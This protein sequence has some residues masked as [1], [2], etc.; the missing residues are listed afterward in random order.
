MSKLSKTILNTIHKQKI[1][2]RSRW[3]FIALH[4]V[5]WVCFG[6]TLIIGIV[7]VS[8]LFLEMNMPER[9]YMDWVPLPGPLQIL[10]YLPF[11]WWFGSLLCVS[12]AYFVFH[13]TDRWYRIGTTWIVSILIL[14]SLL[15]WYILH[16][17][18]VNEM[19]ERNMQHLIPP[20]ER[21]RNDFRRWMP[22]PKSG[23]L[24]GKIQAVDDTLYTV[25]CPDKTLWKVTL[26]C[27]TEG[28]KTRQKDIKLNQPIMF[29]GSIQ[30]DET[31]KTFE[32]TDIQIPP[33]N[34]KGKIRNLLLPPPPPQTS[35]KN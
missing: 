34:R 7:A 12:I 3:Y 4:G 23:I 18:K 32:A 35:E 33:H 29:T 13:K 26:N 9:P 19:S 16:I 28:C 30:W 6:I 15:G 1:T 10:P 14:G 22:L 17:T 8:L 20:Y 2:P 5:L 27:A 11:L 21:M 31:N 25:K 24:P